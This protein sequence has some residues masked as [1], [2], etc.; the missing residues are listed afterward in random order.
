MDRYLARL[1]RIAIL[2]GLLS[3]LALV[4]AAPVAA[5]IQ[6]SA[7]LTADAVVPGPGDSS[8][9][10]GATFLFLVD[11]GRSCAFIEF[12]DAIAPSSVVIGEAEV[13]D[14]GPAVITFPVS[15]D[16][17]EFYS[18]C[19]DVDAAVLTAIVANPSGYFLQVATEA[20]P[21]G[22]SRGQIEAFDA[23]INVSFAK[24]AC[25]GKVR[26]VDDINPVTFAPCVNAART[27]DIEPAPAG[28]RYDPKPILF[29]LQASVTDANQTQ[30]LDQAELDGGGSCNP[31]TMTCSIARGYL[32]FG[33]AEG[34]VS[35]QEQ[36]MPTG[37]RFGA[38]V[39][40]VDG[41][42]LEA[43]VDQA[44]A[45]VSFDA[46]GISGTVSVVVFDFRGPIR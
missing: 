14:T 10:G 18:A 24:Y 33:V 1:A 7:D 19:T 12:E 20:A 35:V 39:V 38:A 21:D 45:T 26:S 6:Y 34:E 30:T 3:S 15:G 46:T 28:F 31:G 16:A 9:Q 37:Y 5:E 13:G 2:I 23:G 29:D 11:D 42:P 43:E 22:A 27:G 8:A 4:T 25:P 44:T 32:W 36:T 17:D 41:S 40:S